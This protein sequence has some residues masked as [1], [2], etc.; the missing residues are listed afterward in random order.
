MLHRSGLVRLG[1]MIRGIMAID[2]LTLRARRLLGAIR[3][4]GSVSRATLIRESGL[5]GTAVFRATEELAAAGLVR[6]GETVAAGRGQPSASI[7]ILP[8]AAFA[9]GLSVMTD[10][11]DV[12][13]L[14]LA[15]AVRGRAEVTLPGMPRDAILDAAAAFGHDR[16]A[17]MDIPR[18]RLK[19]MGVAVAG[20]FVGPDRVN[21]GE[22]LADWALLDLHA[23]ASTRLSL[24]VAVENM[25]SAAALGEHLLGVGAGYASLC[26]L[27][28]AAGFGAGI[29][30]DGQLLR[31]RHGNAGEIA[32]MFPLSGRT[33]PNLAT[34]R[35]T[36][37]AHGVATCGI[38]D[39]VA[40]FEPDWPG[41]DAWLAEHVPAFAWA[42]NLLRFALDP[43]ALVLGGRLPRA[44]AHR[45]VAAV[46]WP[47]TTLP[48]RRDRR[49]PATI[50]TVAALDPDLA[51][52]LGA[53]ALIFHATLF[54]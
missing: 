54:G 26:Y 15:G 36:L 50:L 28:V 48:A 14:D 3:R 23:A 38:G 6:A 49:A 2:L 9:L 1:G 17:A 45:I 30:L 10:R 53:A 39:M 19:G 16:L 22:E 18:D 44:L 52:P 51:G 33:T 35:A 7:H 13:L 37:A 5:S 34:L 8:D 43:E 24:P 40:R 27:N 29:V 11:A 42:C 47:E 21:P 41:V 32:G 12:V 31:G 20:Y 25:A 46:E 4:H